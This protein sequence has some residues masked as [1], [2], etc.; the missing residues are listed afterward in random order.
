MAILDSSAS[1]IHSLEHN[2]NSFRL[3]R[4]KMGCVHELLRSRACGIP[5]HYKTKGDICH[6]HD[7]PALYSIN[8]SSLFRDF[9]CFHIEVYSLIFPHAMRLYCGIHEALCSVDILYQRAFR[10]GTLYARLFRRRVELSLRRS[11]GLTCRSRPRT[12]RTRLG[13]VISDMWRQSV[14]RSQTCTR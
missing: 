2:C 10:P 6:L 4:R 12:C 5:Y 11:R 3:Q 8:F 14:V 13:G 9:F 7:Y 1:S